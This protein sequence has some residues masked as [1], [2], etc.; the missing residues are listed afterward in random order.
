[1]SE[2]RKDPVVGRR[3]I[4]SK[5]RG[6]RPLEPHI[7]TDSGHSAFCLFCYRSE[8]KTPK[9][10]MAARPD[11]SPPNGP[12]FKNHGMEAGETINHSHSQPIALPIITNLVQEELDGAFRHYQPKDRCIFCDILNQEL[13]DKIQLVS[14]NDD[15]AAIAP[16]ASRYPFF[17]SGSGFEINPTLPEE[18]ARYL[19]EAKQ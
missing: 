3:I 11:G 13:R 14:E 2:L 4:I 16:Y 7:P 19:R 9:E 8:P 12:G 6:K 1:M 18:A 15:F 10:I 17:E 5:S